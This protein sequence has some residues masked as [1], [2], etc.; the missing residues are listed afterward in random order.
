[1]ALS[2]ASRGE[3]DRAQAYLEESLALSRSLRDRRGMAFSLNDLG[4]VARKQG[5]YERARGH[6]E[7]SLSL[8]LQFGDNWLI[9]NSYRN[10]AGVATEAGDEERAADLLPQSL[11]L[12]QALGDRWGIAQCLELGG[13]L[14]AGR[15]RW[16]AAAQLLAGAEALRRSIDTQL[17]PY[18]LEAHEHVLRT[19]RTAVGEERLTVLWERVRAL[20][21]DDLVAMLAMAIE[22]GE[23][24]PSLAETH[25]PSDASGPTPEQS[26]A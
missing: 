19:V 22:A 14:A 18:E 20:S 23:T 15:E 26:P 8:L 3:Y 10:L 11:A 25:S 13:R 12:F 17:D 1:L 5:A 24:T 6:F 7:E 21:L 4:E 9:A 2:L 16:A